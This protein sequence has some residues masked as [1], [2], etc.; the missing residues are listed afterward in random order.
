MTDFLRLAVIFIAAVNPAWAALVYTRLHN[1]G[2]EPSWQTR[3]V[4]VAIGTAIAA[5]MLV[6]AALLADPLLDA[7]DIQPETFRVAA[8]IVMAGMGVVTV[9]GRRPLEVDTPAAWTNG[10]YP[11]AVPLFAGP[12]ALVA[13]VIYSLDE[14]LGRA[15]AAGAIALALAA[16]L[17]LFSSRAARPFLAAAAPLLG[18]L[19]V[20][21]AAG[22]IV[23]GVQAI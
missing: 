14:G 18:A 11:L 16:V 13:A 4:P 15:L 6:A 20:L 7:L 17:A 23:D 22:L 21:V 1:P 12:A 9:I 8:G 5:A 2:H 3:A 19:L 10:V